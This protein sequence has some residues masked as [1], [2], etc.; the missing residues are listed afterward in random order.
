[1]EYV[2]YFVLHPLHLL[3]LQVVHHLAAVAVVV[4]VPLVLHLQAALHHLQV[5]VAV[6]VALRPL[7]L[8]L[9][10]D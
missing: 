10:P 1:M 8:L 4:V 7:A 6:A 2:V 5:V 3:L 9:I